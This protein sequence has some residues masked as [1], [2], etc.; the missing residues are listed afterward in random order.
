MG[1]G[2]QPVTGSL[3]VASDA[4]DGSLLAACREIRPLIGDAAVTR[5]PGLLVARYLAADPVLIADDGVDEVTVVTG[6][7]FFAVLDAPRPVEELASATT[8]STTSTTLPDTAASS[9]STTPV[10]GGTDGGGEGT[11]TTT[12]PEEKPYLP[13]TPPPGESCG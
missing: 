10:G 2:G 9:T 1:L 7:D 8:S 11:T 6:P 5:L 4:I 13:G 3:L 12:V